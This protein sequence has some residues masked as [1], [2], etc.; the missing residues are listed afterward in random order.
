VS[1]GEG[2]RLAAGEAT[3]RRSE[4]LRKLATAAL[5]FNSTVEIDELLAIVAA[6]ARDVIGARH[7]SA[8]LEP[9]PDEDGL[10]ARVRGENRPVR[11][12]Q[13]LAAPLVGR[14]GNVLGLLRLSDREDGEFTDEDEALLVQL[15]QLASSAVEN[16][17][18]YRDQARRADELAAIYRLADAVARAETL[19]AVFAAALDALEQAIGVDRAA[20][21]LFN[22]AG[23]IDFRAWRGLSDAYRE[24]VQGRSAW[25]DRVSDPAPFVVDDVLADDEVQELH[26]AFHDEG[27]RSMALVPLVHGG[28]V[29]GRFVLYGGRPGAFTTEEVQLAEAMASHVA[30]AAHRRRTEGAVRESRNQL[31]AIFRSVG[32]GI[33]AQAPDGTIVF[34]NEAAARF[35]GF[36]SLDDFLTTPVDEILQRFELL[37]EHGA[38]LPLAELPGRIALVEGRE[39]E[40][41]LQYRVRA[42]G[43]RRWSLVRATPVFD[44]DGAV[45]LAINVVHELTRQRRAEERLRVLADAGRTL[46][47]SLAVDETLAQIARLMVPAIAD[48][49]LV[50]LLGDDGS[51]Q[52]VVHIHVDRAGEE[53]LDELRRR[54]PVLGNPAHPVARV[55]ATRE[56]HL[57]TAH[58]DQALDA[59]ALDAEHRELYRRL[60]PSSFL[61]APL[62]ARGRTLG[63]ISLGT[64]E[65]SGR[66]LD[67]D[68]LALAVEL[69]ER[70]ALAVDNAL[71]YQEAQ[72]EVA[73]RQRTEAR[74]RALGQASEVLAGSLDYE[75]TLRTVARLVVPSVADWCIVYER[76]PDG[77]IRR[78]AV[79][80]AGGQ[81]ERVRAVLD[82]YPLDVDAEHGVPAVVRTGVPEL[83]EDETAERLTRDVEDP[84][85][86]VQELGDIAPRSSI[87]V[88]LIARGRTLGAIALLAAE[89]GR[90]YGP[91]DFG[92]AVELARRAAVAVD[93]A[94]LFREAQESFA[95]L[96]TFLGAAPVGLAFL[97]TDL[98]FV[99]V[100]Q[101]L[102]DA[103][104]APVERHV[105]RRPAE[106]AAA[107][108]VGEPLLETVL[109]TRKPIIGKELQAPDGR[110]FL[111]SYYPVREPGGTLLGIG[112]IVADITERRRAEQTLRFLSSA[113]EL[114]ARSFDVEE[115]LREVAELAVG[116]LADTCAVYVAENGLLRRVATAPARGEQVATLATELDVVQQAGHVLVETFQRREPLLVRGADAG[117]P[118]VGSM[119]CVPLLRGHE[120]FGALTLCTSGGGR[121]YTQ[122][123]AALAQELA[124][125]AAIALENARLHA[126]TERRAQAAQALE[127]VGDGVFLVDGAGIVRLWNPAAER[128]AHL[129]AQDVLGGVARER[130]AGWPLDRLTARQQTFPVDVDGRELWLSMTAVP[131]PDG[132]V[133]TFRD[134][135]EEYALERLKT[136]FVSTVSH[137]LRTPLA[138]VYG[139]AMTLL[140]TDVPLSDDQRSGLLDV[141][142]GE[143]ERLARIVNDVL[144]ASRLDSGIL[145]VSIESCD[146][147]A[148]VTAVASVARA[149][150]PPGIELVAD[151]HPDTPLVAGDPDKVRQV[152]VNLVD[153]ASKY[154]PDGGLVEVRVAPAERWVRFTV[155][156]RGLGIPEAEHSR[157]FEKF[158]RLDPNL[159]RGVGGTGLGL[160]ICRELVRRM[161]GRIGVESVEGAGST[162]WFELP[163]AEGTAAGGLM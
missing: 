119:L 70:A 16:A 116:S 42:T 148:L 90:R 131:F 4:G 26:D 142:V 129:P 89:S 61:A 66:R 88:P 41:L 114:L 62:V 157:I 93:N 7:A 50:D 144:W 139:A 107:S 5:L 133:Y 15:A 47:S 54:Y 100:N 51:L 140:R 38:P 63:A 125:R 31:E 146:A 85:G 33:T 74:L 118:G 40:R 159:T 13:E 71:L 34:A 29:L 113:S 44:E 43:E 19:D 115:N 11:A 22:A 121:P 45:R 145:D 46:S 153:N 10:A 78:L 18:L 83:V 87:R 163:V 128:I 1:V 96:D 138:A 135:T 132:T 49:C 117:L 141:V 86:L 111:A 39:S 149:H 69:A 67:E 151:V 55:V 24:R 161:D 154:S 97:D 30:A 59:I 80:H 160:Y 112:A 64:S 92:F 23:A 152:L 2:E 27:I 73:E 35:S 103:N 155:S 104:G 60:A 108:I 122:E 79:E 21:V 105:G 52:H 14:D 126:E 147:A 57:Q 56:P 91:D 162:F 48:Y 95:R 6:Q 124:R 158:F 81:A 156:D 68:D 58:A 109:E 65:G 12:A 77:S 127:L 130:L 98:R 110:T 25:A 94:L 75:E 8:S 106:V 134:L 101:W 150:L 72:E 9:S 120:A 136:D 37:D 76:R 20:V 143:S 82:R 99:Q 102:A 53:A 32:D 123:D 3:E 17:G 84:S 28:V 36:A 137:E